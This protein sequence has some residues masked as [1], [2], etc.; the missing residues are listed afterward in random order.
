MTW[1]P[2]SSQDA[3]EHRDADTSTP[4]IHAD[5]CAGGWLGED[6]HGRPIP[7]LTCRPHLDP[8]RKTHP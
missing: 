1:P 8:A 2:V 5:T 6:Q 4:D 7:C 3:Q